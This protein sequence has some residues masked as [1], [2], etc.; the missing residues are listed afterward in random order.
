[1]KFGAASPSA[2][3]QVTFSRGYHSL[4]IPHHETVSTTIQPPYSSTKGYLRLGKHVGDAALERVGRGEVAAGLAVADRVVVRQVGDGAGHALVPEPRRVPH[5]RGVRPGGRVERR[6]V[7]ALLGGVRHLVEGL[8]EA[9]EPALAKPARR[10]RAGVE[11]VLR[12]P[13]HGTAPWH[14]LEP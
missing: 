4:G 13:L 12:L 6:A 3:R 5:R 1:M 7:S 8:I 9:R 10:P 2:C 11:R 14:R